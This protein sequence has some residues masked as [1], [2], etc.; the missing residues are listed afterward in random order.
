LSLK[1]TTIMHRRA[2][3]ARQKCDVS[4]SFV[5]TNSTPFAPRF[6]APR[7]LAALAASTLLAS[8]L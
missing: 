8:T 4:T 5:L 6:A 2:C 1:F 7:T 3:V